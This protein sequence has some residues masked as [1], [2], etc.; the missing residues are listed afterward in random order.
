MRERGRQCS[1]LIG[2]LAMKLDK[3]V[4]RLCDKEHIG[5]TS[6]LAEELGVGNPDATRGKLLAL[7]EGDRGYLGVYLLAIYVVDDTD[8][9]SDGEIYWWSVPALVDG[10]GK[11]RKEVLAGL[12][13]GATPHKCGDHEWMTNISLDDPPLL[14]IIPPVDEVHGCVVRLAIYDDDGDVADLPSAMSAGLWALAAVPGDPLPGPEQLITPVR[15]AIARTLKSDDDDILLDQDVPIRRGEVVRFGRGMVGAVVNAMVRAYYFVRDE[16]HC[17]EFG[18]ITL[19]KGQ[20]E[21]IRFPVPIEQGGRLAVFARGADVHCAALGDLT[22]DVPF[23]NRVLSGEQ[24]KQ[25]AEGMPVI[26]TG[27]AKLVAFYTPPEK[28]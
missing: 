24:Q 13:N 17:H 11:T 3:L 4:S 10:E 15:D 26:A 21:H 22:V 20:T 7:A 5:L 19:Q 25:L 1:H 28:H 9:W 2:S 27:P 14:A 12:P 6:P 8:F 18:P 16:D 23:K